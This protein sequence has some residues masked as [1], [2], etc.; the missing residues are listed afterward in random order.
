MKLIIS[1]AAVL[2]FMA[3]QG[4]AADY[5]V[6][7]DTGSSHVGPDS[8]ATY[9]AGADDGSCGAAN[10]ACATISQAITNA[11]NNDTIY[12]L[13]AVDAFNG[14]Y[15]EDLIILEVLDFSADGTAEIV[16]QTAGAGSELMYIN[17][18]TGPV[19]FL[20]DWVFDDG[21]NSE[22]FI[23]AIQG[24]HV[25]GGGG[26]SLT[27]Q[28]TVST[29]VFEDFGSGGITPETVITNLSGTCNNDWF[30]GD[31][32][33]DFEVTS[34]TITAS[35]ACRITDPAA[36]GVDYDFDSVTITG[37]TSASFFY[38]ERTDTDF[39]FH[40][41]TI[42][43]TGSSNAIALQDHATAAGT[44][45][46]DDN[47]VDLDAT[48]TN[49]PLHI[50]A[51]TWDVRIDGNDIEQ[52]VDLPAG[53][54]LIEITNATDPEITNNTIMYAQEGGMTQVDYLIVVEAVVSAGSYG[55]ATISGNTLTAHG[56]ETNMIQ[57]LSDG[58]SQNIS[59][60]IIGNTLYGAVWF[61][62][63]NG[64][65]NA[66]SIHVKGVEHARIERNKLYG[67][68]SVLWKGGEGFHTAASGDDGFF[69][70]FG[71]AYPVH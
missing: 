46:F 71:P 36:N 1:I 38:S 17:E 39:Y 24:G 12:V 56:S 35:G 58:D 65:F 28:Q 60:D 22:T 69:F 13:G 55:T 68:I 37:T 26:G 49:A 34:G 45:Y 8:G 42:E 47:D 41:G 21:G 18:A 52:T 31:A 16:G 11:S 54:K 70:N 15:G 64:D 50:E 57:C 66:H 30:H 27:I 40:D 51:G 48:T 43:V 23:D 32:G 10:D 6:N 9:S 33:A 29:N 61:G 4:W 20:G 14:Q 7:G 62:T 63:T 44:W 19:R 53:G 3:G 25:F 67:T 5:Y 59:C 2:L